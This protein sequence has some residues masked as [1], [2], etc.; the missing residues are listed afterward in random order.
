MTRLVFLFVALLSTSVFAQNDEAFKEGFHYTLINDA[1]ATTAGDAVTAY[2]IFDY[3]CPH[4]YSFQSFVTAW[5]KKLPENV[6]FIRVP[7]IFSPAREP[8]GRAYLTSEMLG[9]ADKGHDDLFTA[10]HKDKKQI[11]SIEDAADFYAQYGVDKAKFLSTAS[12]FAVD[13]KV[14]KDQALVRKWGV[15]G[16]PSLVINGKYLISV[17]KDVPQ[18]KMIEVANYLIAKELAK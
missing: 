13:A 9:V 17:S 1:S 8:L 16:T 3:L 11:R 6:E 5:E 10:I 7:A 14:R 15:R 4:C 2:E 18:P 12:S